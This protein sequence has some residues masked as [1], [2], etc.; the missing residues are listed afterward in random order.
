[1]GEIK[2]Y[3]GSCHCGKVSYEATT[4]LGRV[5]ECNCSH[6]S[7]KG[8]RLTFVGPDAFK[9]LSGEGELTEY[10]FNKHRIHHLFCKT[11]GI[12]SYGWGTRP[13]GTKA[14]SVNVRCLED[15]EPDA[16]T[17]TQVDGRSL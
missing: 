2:T 17:V 16:Y 3:R 4:D 11:C 12:Q 10:Q 6:C 13:D 5:L 14:Y 8:F 1:M 9:L 15:V 7:R